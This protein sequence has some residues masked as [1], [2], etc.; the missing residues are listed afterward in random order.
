M[1]QPYLHRSHAGLVRRVLARAARAM[2]FDQATVWLVDTQSRHVLVSTE[3]TVLDETNGEL[4]DTDG[5]YLEV[6]LAEP[7]QGSARLALTRS[8]GRPIS[9]EDVTR[10]AD[11]GGMVV[12]LLDQ[13]ERAMSAARHEAEQRLTRALAAGEIGPWYQP[14]IA[15]QTG[16]IVGVE[17]L[18]RWRTP[19]GSVVVPDLFIPVAE[20]TDLIIDL[21][22]MMIKRAVL[23]LRHWQ[24]KAPD[25]HVSVNLSG[26]HLDRA[27]WDQAI[28]D[29]VV[30]T[31]AEP[32]AIDLE[33]TETA[34][35]FDLQASGA[36]IQQ[37]RRKGFRIW[38]DDIGSGASSLDMLL[39]IPVD[40]LKM[41]RTFTQR[42]GTPNEP[43]IH[44]IIRDA[45]QR[46]VK[47]T[48]EGIETA[49]QVEGAR[50][51]GCDYGQGYF[52]SPAV[53]AA[54]IEELLTPEHAG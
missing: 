48:L 45:A 20:R 7:D 38:F 27:G 43:R 52:W 33:L 22:H 44:G 8:P 53:P 32:S 12:E 2:D 25:L 29:L 21:D 54:A 46:R 31:E 4:G 35:P 26:R 42:L 14:I 19:R 40:G 37:L 49:E 17:A 1:W 23:D 18:A 28:Y 11:L 24:R 36:A 6:P 34:D 3:W 30:R 50:R 51:L 16:T 47:V 5:G 13:L 10:A 41:E 39:S 9:R 15:M